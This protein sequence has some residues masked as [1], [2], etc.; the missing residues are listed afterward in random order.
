VS[1]PAGDFVADTQ[2]EPRAGEPGRFDGAIPVAWQIV[3]AFGGMIMSVALRAMQD[4]LARPELRLVSANAMFVDRVPCGPVTIDV[5]VLRSGKRVA[6]VAS[7]LRVRGNEGVALHTHAVFGVDHD[8]EHALQEVEFPDVPAP[9][10]CDPPPPQSEDDDDR[11]WGHVNCFEQNDWRPA[12]GIAP[13]LPSY[14]KGEARMCSWVRLVKEPLLADGTHDPIALAFYADQIG[15]A[16]GQ[17]LGPTDPHFMLTLEL[18]IRFI[19]A[20]TTPWVLQDA[21]AWHVGD[22]YATGPTRL[23]GADRKLLAIATQTA[24][25]RFVNR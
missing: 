16:V 3:D 12:S 8:Q 13:W 11:G 18:G 2:V 6:Q 7:R 5:E 25:L 15:S 1:V 19:A 10:E 22:G 24:N 23:W 4:E 21:E 20:P 9:E 14:G 17:G